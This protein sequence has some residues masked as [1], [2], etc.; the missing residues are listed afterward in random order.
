MWWTRRRAK[1]NAALIRERPQD[2]G[3]GAEAPIRTVTQDLLRR[4]DYAERIANVLADLRVHEGRVFAIRGGWGFGKSSL[5]NLISEKL[6]EDGRQ[7]DWLDF[8]PWQWG[9]GD[10]IARALFGQLA[11]KL[12]GDHSK[13]ALERAK[14]LRRYGE[15]L[16]GSGE[17]LRKISTSPHI[18]SFLT[19][20]TVVLVASAIGFEP[21]NAAT[22]VGIL[23][24]SSFVAPPIGRWIAHFWRDRSGASLDEIRR[25]LEGRLRTLEHP[26]VVFVDDIDRLEPEQIRM[27]LRQVK[28]NANLPNIVFV[29]LFQVDIIEAALDSVSNKGGRSFLEKIVQTNFD[30]PAVPTNVVHR[31][32]AEELSALVGTYATEENGFSQRR[33][34]NAFVGCVKPMLRNM[35]DARRLISSIAVHLPLH[36]EGDVCE[37]NIID[38]IVLEALRVFEPDLLQAI[39]QGQDLVLQQMRYGHG[40]RD[41]DRQAAE[42]LL[43]SSSEERRIIA[44][45]TIKELFPPLEWAYGGTNY[46]DGFHERWFSEKRVCTARYFPRYFEMQT[47]DG[48][49][50]ERRFFEFIE[51]TGSEA[52]LTEIVARFERDRLLPS[53]VARFDESNDRLPVQNAAILLP[54]M[55]RIAQRFSDDRGA[56]PFN[57]PWLSAWRAT[58]WYLKRVPEFQRGELALQALR[59]TQSLAVAAILIHLSDPEDNRREGEGFVPTLTQEAV[60]AMKAEWL[61][62]IRVRAAPGGNL[63]EDPGLISLIYRWR[64]YTASLDEP[65]AFVTRSI[66]SDEGFSRIVSQFMNT[67]TTH[68]AGDRVS[69]VTYRFNRETISDFIGIEVAEARCAAINANDFPEHKKA[70]ETL[71]TS[72]D[73]WSGRRPANPFD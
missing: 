22:V 32:F 65:K 72:L 53:L 26:L 18:A 1:Q 35:R 29:L 66:Q 57:S 51:A 15:I 8:N 46:G 17:K 14:A 45:D 37:V 19:N 38:F 31:I 62:I 6:D 59:A 12:G 60:N 68:S 61:R 39:F 27:L 44:R 25:D 52:A 55:F 48:E 2:L 30:L 54:E 43:E 24:V 28:A 34:G 9:D 69:T 64:D 3:V 71:V 11:D 73:G 70:L 63:I 67:G 20:A 47:A 58:S 40:R 23:A 10:A 56:D 13:D 36:I 42:S 5:K 49:I 33:W 41:A 7:V 4:A 21:P 50:S 16:T